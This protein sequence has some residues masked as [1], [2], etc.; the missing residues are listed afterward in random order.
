MRKVMPFW[1]LGLLSGLIWA[2]WHVPAI[3]FSDY[4]AGAGNSS[5]RML[6]FILG[7]VPEGLIYAYFCW[8]A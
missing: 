3:L 2:L 1:A 4:N 8:R 7:I 5:F 6:M